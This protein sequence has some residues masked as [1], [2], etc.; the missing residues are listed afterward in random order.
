[1][2]HDCHNNNCLIHM[3]IIIINL[4]HEKYMTFEMRLAIDWEFFLYWRAFIHCKS[5]IYY[6]YSLIS[7]QYLDKLE[8]V[9]Y[10][11]NYILIHVIII[12]V[13]CDDKLALWKYVSYIQRKKYSC[14]EWKKWKVVP[15]LSYIL[16][17]FNTKIY[18]NK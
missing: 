12:P 13:S 7:A 2:I 8:W 17:R 14:A 1:M 16:I 5:C 11:L 10:Y 15:K 3:T 4:P 6:I 18:Q 9:S